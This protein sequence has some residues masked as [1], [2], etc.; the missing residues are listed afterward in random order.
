MSKSFM[1]GVLAVLAVLLYIMTSLVKAPEDK[2]AS[3]NSNPPPA[4]QSASKPAPSPAPAASSIPPSKPV[5]P[6]KPPA[7]KPPKGGKAPEAIGVSDDWFTKG[8]DG[9]EGLKLL[10]SQAQDAGK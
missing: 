7:Y 5:T 8:K 2:D 4:Q 10:H 6:P 9:P 1:F 3:A